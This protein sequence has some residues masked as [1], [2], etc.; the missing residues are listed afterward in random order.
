MDCLECIQ[1]GLKKHPN[2]ARRSQYQEGKG[3]QRNPVVA[4]G[5]L[6]AVG[7][8]EWQGDRGDEACPGH[9]IEKQAA[10]GCALCDQLSVENGKDGVKERPHQPNGESKAVL[11]LEIPG[12]KEDAGNDNTSAQ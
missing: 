4:G 11:S 8:N 7:R 6:E 5:K 9:F 3:E 10:G 12:D 1:N 2:G